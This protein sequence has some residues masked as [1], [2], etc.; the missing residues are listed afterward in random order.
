MATKKEREEQEA[1][2]KSKVK[3]LDDES[4]SLTNQLKLYLKINQAK[5]EEL[6]F[7]TQIKDIGRKAVI[8][9]NKYEK[10]TQEIKK[11][12]K[13]LIDAKRAGDRDGARFTQ[14][15]ITDE[16]KR[17][18]Q[19]KSTAGGALKAMELEA[20]K[21]K[22]S[23]IVEKGLISDINKQRG[24]GAKIADLF[25]TKEAKQKSIDIARAKAGGGVNTGSGAD[26]KPGKG[27]DL[28]QT[29]KWGALIAGIKSL[30][31]PV[32]AAGKVAKEAIV[33][34][35]AEAAALI[36]GESYGMGGG[37]ANAGGATSILGGL[38]KIASALP[39]I[40]GIAGGLIGLFKGIVDAVL[41]IDQAN[42]R[43]ARS[44]NISAEA[45][46]QMRKDFTATAMASG[47]IVVN[48]TRMLQ[49]QI[50]I[51]NQLGINK[52]L[53][54]D[55]LINDVKLRDILGLEA[56]S[57]K[58]ISD[59]AIITGRNAEELTKSVIGTVGAF[60]QLVGTSFKWSSILSEAS[61][62]TGLLGLTLAKFPEKIY[63]AVIATKALGFDLKQLDST[64]NSFLDFE[65]SISKE[66]EAQVLTGKALNLTAA[67]E[68]ALNN[69]N[70][71]L[72]AE[73]TKNVG[74]ASEYLRMN[75]I[76][77]EGIAAAVG[78]TRDSLADVLKKQEIY[79]RA[80]VTDQKG[81]VTKLQMLEKQK[82]LQEDISKV[83]GKDGYEIASQ[84][85]T[86]ER[87][88]EVMESIKRTFV[89]F[90]RNSGLFDFITNPQKVNAFVANLSDKLAGTVSII[91]KIV[92][93]M[94]EGISHLPFFDKEAF[95]GLA[96]QVRSGT[97][98][99]AGSIRTIG[100]SIQGTTA[101]SIGGT[102]EK[103]TKQQN[104]PATPA[105][106]GKGVVAVSTPVTIEHKMDSYAIGQTTFDVYTQL[107]GQNFA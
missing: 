59:Q 7:Q 90:V 100:T 88:T 50:E 46:N 18:A 83:L 28:E 85:S 98:E 38:E 61:K 14:N 5:K 66:M 79:T 65:S 53:S 78:L 1:L 93:L 12:E 87:L 49:S 94:L 58:L 76:Q 77:Q 89:E 27:G 71:T 96:A 22:D 16:K 95:Q 33:T 15:A 10:T 64:A 54:D 4:L 91:G 104:A 52:Q 97:G 60:N 40:G 9:A 105:Q 68:A 69:D 70:A 43:V 67:R 20:K 35:F 25:R 57:R 34:P 48:S 47:N 101:P 81:L 56:E 86:A 2:E 62:L 51:G 106:Q 30:E 29:G 74:S 32:K 99:F 103:G 17:Q 6:N 72:A 13:E 63:K 44:M 31:A 37:K 26:G 45:A 75:R 8:E 39:L 11:L 23:L 73:I 92:A 107:Q 3:M 102:I 84:V 21:R 42:F 55:I 41:G 24:F 19:L 82:M 36:T 80:G